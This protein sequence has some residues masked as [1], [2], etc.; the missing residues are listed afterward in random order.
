MKVPKKNRSGNKESYIQQKCSLKIGEKLRHS[1]VK[2]RGHNFRM[3]TIIP[4][5]PQR[6]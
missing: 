1:G 6:K 3:L 5:V 4:K 2:I